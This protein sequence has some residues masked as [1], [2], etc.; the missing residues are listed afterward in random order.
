MAGARHRANHDRPETLLRNPRQ[1]GFRDKSFFCSI[2]GGGMF[3]ALGLLS[4]SL[5]LCVFA[6]T[7][8]SSARRDIR[9]KDIE[10]D[11][12]GGSMPKCFSVFLLAALPLLG[13]DAESCKE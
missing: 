10:I 7:F 12:T 1:G 2:V 6:R 8:S 4:G 5:R 11:L 13:Q 3:R 9:V